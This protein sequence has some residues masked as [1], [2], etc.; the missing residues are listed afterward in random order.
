MERKTRG[1]PMLYDKV[2]RALPRNEL[3]SPATIADFARAKGL[4][5][6]DRQ[7][8]ERVRA[9]MVRFCNNHGFP[10]DGDGV[11]TLVGNAPTPAWFGWRWQEAIG[12]PIS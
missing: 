11:I 10:N 9:S 7:S 8:R 12:G 2:L 3:F 4:I 5:P 6:K 1:R